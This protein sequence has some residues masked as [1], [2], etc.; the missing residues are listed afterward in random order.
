[1]PA[2]AWVEQ[3]DKRGLGQF[4]AACEILENTLRSGRPPAGRAEAIPRSRT[5][6]WE[7]KVTK[8]GGTPPHLRLLYVRERSTLWAATGF[9][10][11]QNQLTDGEVAAGD[12]VAEAWFTSRGET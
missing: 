7:L 2:L 9:T 4:R 6:L 3:L 10:K 5:G 12:A 1:M 8:P 11:K